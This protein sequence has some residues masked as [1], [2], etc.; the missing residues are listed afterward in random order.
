M[1]E[2]PSFIR[3][4]LTLGCALIGLQAPSV[5]KADGGALRY[6]ER[7]GGYEIAVFTA[8]PAVRVG[9]VDISV[10]VQDSGTSKPVSNVEIDVQ[11]EGAETVLDERA[12]AELATNKLLQAAH[13]DLPFPGTWK[14]H[15]RVRG[16]GGDESITFDI[17]VGEPLP[18]WRTWWQWIVWPFAAIAL[19]L[20]LQYR[21]RPGIIARKQNG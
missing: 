3:V 21:N 6:L 11:L 12:T 5:A 13:F 10:L 9:P 17:E 14:V 20:F 2:Q 16:P 8:P 19:F 4:F 7:K 18:P 15:V 1:V